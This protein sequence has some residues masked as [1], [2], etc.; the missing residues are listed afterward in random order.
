M[1]NNTAK[2]DTIID[3]SLILLYP[4]L[5]TFLTLAFLP[6][7]AS[8]LLP[9]LMS[10]LLVGLQIRLTLVISPAGQLS[11]TSGYFS[12]G[13]LSL[14]TPILLGFFISKSLARSVL[15]TLENLSFNT[16]VF[17]ALIKACFLFIKGSGSF[18]Q[19]T[20]SEADSDR[21]RVRKLC[22]LKLLF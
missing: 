2:V 15:S 12:L 9:D 4:Y 16:Y 11:P 20:H 6:F 7:Q 10:Y 22:D 5:F 19:F 8:L 18:L 14:R 13:Q 17:I 3:Q 21:G 1:C